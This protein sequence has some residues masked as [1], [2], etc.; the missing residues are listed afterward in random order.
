[1]KKQKRTARKGNA[2]T[3]ARSRRE[4]IL[5]PEEVLKRFES[6]KGQAEFNAAM[7]KWGKKTAPLIQV[8]KDAENLTAEDYGL[9]VR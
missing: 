8:C 3:K 7:K 4:C 6:A 9:I 1:V 2:A 5:D